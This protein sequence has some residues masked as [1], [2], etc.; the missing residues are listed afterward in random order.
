MGLP[1][2]FLILLKQ[3]IQPLKRSAL[4]MCLLLPRAFPA[5]STIPITLIIPINLIIPAVPA[6]PVAPA[7]PAAPVA[8][9][10]PA[11]PVEGALAS[12]LVEQAMDILMN[13]VVRGLWDGRHPDAMYAIMRRV[14][15]LNGRK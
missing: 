9:A 15:A 1:V 2:K 3:P 12:L 5:V 14:R 13:P 4:R 10:A 11:V 8:P 7:V 6:V